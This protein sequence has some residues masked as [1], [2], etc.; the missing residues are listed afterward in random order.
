MKKFNITIFLLMLIS[1]IFAGKVGEELE[2]RGVY[3]D[4]E[5]GIR[6]NIRV[7]ENQFQ[8]Y[9]VDEQNII[10]EPPVKDIILDLDSSRGRQD[11]WHAILEPAQEGDFL[12]AARTIYPPFHFD[13]RVLL[14]YP[15]ESQNQAYANWQFSQAIDEPEND[16]ESE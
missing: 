14:R 5:D 7:E 2:K 4:L 1:P 15:D 13:M 9:F 12:T 8:A 3:K 11:N 16:Q 10:T 6:L